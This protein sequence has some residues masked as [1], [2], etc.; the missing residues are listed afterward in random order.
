MPVVR[1]VKVSLR[2]S[3]TDRCM[4]DHCGTS[5]VVPTSLVVRNVRYQ[6]GVAHWVLTVEVHVGFVLQEV[7]LGQVPPMFSRLLSFCHAPY[8]SISSKSHFS[9]Y[10]LVTVSNDDGW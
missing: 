7:A 9:R 1:N 5:V 3:P 6:C 8:S 10:D 2:N 4:P